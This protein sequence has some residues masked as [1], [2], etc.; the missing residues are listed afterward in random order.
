MTARSRAA[1]FLRVVIGAA[2]LV[3]ATCSLIDLPRR[4][5]PRARGAV[6][7]VVRDPAARFEF[8]ARGPDGTRVLEAL[9]DESVVFSNAGAIATSA[10]P[11]C[12]A[13]LA[14]RELHRHSG[15]DEFRAW[16]DGESTRID[17][18]IDAP[19][20]LL[21]LPARLVPIADWLDPAANWS[22]GI[23]YIEFDAREYDPAIVLTQLRSFLSRIDDWKALFVAVTVLRGGSKSNSPLDPSSLAMPTLVKFPNAVAGGRRSPI[24]IDPIDLGEA[25]SDFMAP[26]KVRSKLERLLDDESREA[27]RYSFAGDR[28]AGV[29]RVSSGRWQFVQQSKG[30][31]SEMALESLFDLDS[32]ESTN[33]DRSKERPEI[34][35]QLRLA[36]LRWRAR[37]GDALLACENAL[38][39]DLLYHPPV[40]L[41]PPA[42]E[43][44]RLIYK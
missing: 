10:A 19:R 9:L 5:A 22:G 25:L 33:L 24:P 26:V 2:M 13:L 34:A 3:A 37:N 39:I 23:L 30:R 11:N 40:I 29:Y 14:G 35:S 1:S 8:E 43:P 4:I 28:A 21:R 7:V 42:G 32:F 36:L 15:I 17:G 6:I 18:S 38:P 16:R 31:I 27:G 44:A 41:A 20:V 12:A